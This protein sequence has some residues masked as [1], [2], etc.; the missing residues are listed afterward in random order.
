MV[1]NPHESV[2]QLT[3]AER[4]P[5]LAQCGPDNGNGHKIHEQIIL[6]GKS[7][8]QIEL[9]KPYPCHQDTNIPQ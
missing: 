7:E 3:V 6:F 1:A 5:D 8:I 4:G 2:F 9:E